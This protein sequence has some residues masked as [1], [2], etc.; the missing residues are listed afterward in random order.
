MT[1]LPEHIVFVT[2][3]GEASTLAITRSLGKRGVKVV[4]GYT[5]A[6]TTTFLSRHCFKRVLYRDPLYGE[7][8]V[9][10]VLEAVTKYN[11]DILFPVTDFS[12]MEIS[13]R[14]KEFERRNVKV[15]IPPHDAILTARDK[16]LTLK[17]AEKEGI[18]HPK[19]L[20]LNNIKE[21]KEL[22]N[23]IKFP[24]VV[25]PRNSCGG[26]GMEYVYSEAQ[27]KN[28]FYNIKR[29][30]G[31]YPLVQEFVPGRENVYSVACVFDEKSRLKASI[32]MRKIREDPPSGGACTFGE[33]VW[34][35]RIENIGVSLLKKM[36]WYGTATVELKI[37]PRDDVPKLME[38]NPRWL[39]YASLAI[40]AGIDLPYIL[41]TTTI[42]ENIPRVMKYEVGLKFSRSLHDLH[43]FIVKFLPTAKN[44]KREILKFVK[45][46][47]HGRTSFDLFSFSDPLP[48]LGFALDILLRNIGL[49]HKYDPAKYSFRVTETLLDPPH[50]IWLP[51]KT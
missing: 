27:L 49:H 39:G 23:K 38:V 43:T 22:R 30:F 10:D 14:R 37:D 1:S 42:G 20:V 5:H 40:N 32:V 44:K 9:A 47:F 31:H 36:R 25:K 33:T 12:L 41:Y 24:V 48:L 46:Y 15:P 21:L 51:K 26:A 13:L 18:P 6:V 7:K 8:F 3:G 17:F 11:C 4:V 28:A 16:L 45:S 35:P 29:S 34:N 19:T 50:Y 2:D